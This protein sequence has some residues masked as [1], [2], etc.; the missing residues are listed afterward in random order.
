MPK[1]AIYE[2]SSALRCKEK[3]RSSSDFFNASSPT[4]DSP[5]HKVRSKAQ[6]SRSVRRGGDRLHISRALGRCLKF[7]QELS[8]LCLRDR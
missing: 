8:S 6:L 4:S 7:Q 3:I 1:T 5:P 2:D